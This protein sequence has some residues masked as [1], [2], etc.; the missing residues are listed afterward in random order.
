[1]ELSFEQKEALEVAVA[2]YK[3]GMKYTCI[4]GYA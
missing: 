3:A 2:R 4:A 1:M